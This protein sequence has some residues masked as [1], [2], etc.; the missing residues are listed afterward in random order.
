VSICWYSCA[1]QSR[2]TCR[3]ASYPETFIQSIR[4]LWREAQV[5]D[6]TVPVTLT[7]SVAATGICGVGVSTCVAALQVLGG[8]PA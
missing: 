3:N 2:P 6:T 7:K 1:A 5:V 8:S 4:G